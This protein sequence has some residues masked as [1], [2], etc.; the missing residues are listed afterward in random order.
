MQS[1]KINIERSRRE[2]VDLKTHQEAYKRKY[3]KI[4]KRLAKWEKE[5]M[6]RQFKR[7]NKTFRQKN[8][9]IINKI[10]YKE[11]K[12][13]I[14]LITEEEVANDIMKEILI[15]FCLAYSSPIFKDILC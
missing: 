6:K 8:L 10:E 13:L 11:N 5:K 9:K 4:I 1:I 3:L 12:V 14:Q 2:Y 7:C 15:R